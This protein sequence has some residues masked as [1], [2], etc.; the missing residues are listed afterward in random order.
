MQGPPA[1]S[2]MP[3]C[4]SRTAL[5]TATALASFPPPPLTAPS[6]PCSRVQDMF[7]SV[8]L[9]VNNPHFLIMQG[10]INKVGTAATPTHIFWGGC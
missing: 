8:Q 4:L 10:R 9:N 2:S 3:A 5:T 1:G 6:S 7:H